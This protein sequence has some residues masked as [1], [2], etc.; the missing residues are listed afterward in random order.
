MARRTQLW[1]PFPKVTIEPWEWAATP[2]PGPATAGWGAGCPECRVLPFGLASPLLVRSP[3]PSLCWSATSIHISHGARWCLVSECKRWDD[4][5]RPH[6]WR[7]AWLHPGKGLDQPVPVSTPTPQGEH[8]GPI[9][10]P[11]DWSVAPGWWPV[12]TPRTPSSC[13][14]PRKSLRPCC[15][16]EDSD[17]G[18]RSAPPLAFLSVPPRY[19]LI[20]GK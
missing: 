10:G 8:L 4:S 17:M 3:D 16:G 12:S 15:F 7:P 5:L 1:S 2:G 9:R 11:P 20:I 18:G 14:S 6:A 13:P 19:L